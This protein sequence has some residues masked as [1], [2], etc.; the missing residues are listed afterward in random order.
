[1][2]Q[3]ASTVRTRKR[4]DAST[5]C[6]SIGTSSSSI[7]KKSQLG[8]KQKQQHR[9]KKQIEPP[10]EFV[11][12]P[13][14]RPD[15]KPPDRNNALERVVQHLLRNYNSSPCS[16]LIVDCFSFG[17]VA[18]V[19]G[20]TMDIVGFMELHRQMTTVFPDFHMEYKLVGETSPGVVVAIVQA[21]GTHSGGDY[22]TPTQSTP[23]PA[24]NALCKNDPERLTCTFQGNKIKHC[25]FVPVSPDTSKHGP[26]GFYQQIF[27]HNTKVLRQRK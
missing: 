27:K 1:M 14:E 4:G 9:N 16:K 20:M 25:S 8:R 17:A 6:R 11:P 21:C 26:D 18:E 13:Y 5:G 15:S 12:Y 23:L 10:V 19:P 2:G 22:T 24:M 3:A 7:R